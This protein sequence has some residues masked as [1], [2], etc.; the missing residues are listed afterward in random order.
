LNVPSLIA[1]FLIERLATDQPAVLRHCAPKVFRAPA[2]LHLRFPV[3]VPVL[4]SSPEPRKTR[5]G[6]FDSAVE[7]AAD[8]ERRLLRLLSVLSRRRMLTAEFRSVDALAGPDPARL[9]ATL[10][11]PVLR[12]ECDADPATETRTFVLRL[13][14]PRWS[15]SHRLELE[16]ALQRSFTDAE[17]LLCPRCRCL[18]CR[19]D[20]CD[21]VIWPD[22]ARE[23]WEDSSPARYADHVLEGARPL[24]RLVIAD[25]PLSGDVRL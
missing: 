2:L 24:S 14:P 23:A 4:L 18:F 17:V 19:R 12:I 16:R 22:G 21:C 15:D 5:L 1:D 13:L 3:A 10:E 25:L 6:F 7:S 20:Q 9:S 8:L 11:L